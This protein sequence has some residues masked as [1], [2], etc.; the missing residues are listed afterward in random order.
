MNSS[1]FFSL[2]ILLFFAFLQPVYP[3]KKRFFDYNENLSNSL[4][5]Q[6]YEDNLG[7][8]WVATEDGLNRFDGIRFKPYSKGGN[9]RNS[10]KNNYV[11]SLFEDSKHN[12]WIG[13]INGLQ[14]FNYQNEEFCDVD[15]DFA[16]KK[17]G[18]HLFIKDITETSDGVIWLATTQGLLKIEKGK[19]I[20]LT[21]LN[22]QLNSIFINDILVDSDGLFWLGTRA[23]I[24]TYDPVSGKVKNYI[25]D[26]K[27]K[28]DFNREVSCLCEDNQ[29][30]I[31]V[32][33]ING[34]VS[35][36]LKGKGYIEKINSA[37]Q[38]EENLPVRDVLF[39]SKKRL[40][41]GTDGFGLRILNEN[42][43][44]LERYASANTSFNFFKSKVHTIIEDKAGNIWIGLFQKGIFLIPESPDIFINYGYKTIEENSIGSNCITDIDGNE[45]E[46]WISTDGDG[47]YHLNRKTDK[48]NHILIKN[49][50][51][52]MGGQN[53]LTMYNDASGDLWLGRYINGLIRYNK[54]SGTFK[55][56]KRT[57]TKYNKATYSNI[58]V[59]K[60]MNPDELVVGTLDDGIARFNTTTG[61][62]TCGLDLP[63]SLNNKIPKWILNLQI[64]AKGNF[65]IGTYVGLFYVDMKKPS[66]AQLT[67][68]NNALPDNTVSCLHIDR[69]QNIWAGTYGGIVKIRPGLMTTTFYSKKNGL[70]NNVISAIEEDEAGMIWISTH[71]GLS[72]FNP[73]TRLF[74]N[75]SSYD[76]I[77]ANEFTRNCSFCTEKN[78]LFFGGINGVTQIKR[79]YKECLEKIKDVFL[80]G[81]YLSGKSVNVSEKSGNHVILKKSIVFADTLRFMESDNQFSIGFVSAEI[82]NQSKIGYEYFMDGFDTSWRST[83]SRNRRGTYTNLRHGTY[84]F[85]VRAKDKGLYSKIRKLVIIIF[86]PWY[87]TSWAKL[88]LSVFVVFLCFCIFIFFRER[89]R[90]HHAEKMS[91]MKMQFFINVSHEIKTPLSLILDPLETL[92][93]RSTDDKDKKLL[94]IIQ[95]NANRIRRQVRQL[96]DVRKIDKGQLFVKFQEI[97]IFDFIKEIAE[98]YDVWVVQ[99][100]V[101]FVICPSDPEVTAWIDP[102]NFEKVIHNLL[103]NAFKFTAEG[104]EIKLLIE[105]EKGNN[106]DL[107]LPEYLKI[108]VSDN[109]LGIKEG[110]EE[111][112]F[113]R[114]YQVDAQE[115]RFPSGTGIGLNLS[116]SLVMLHKGKMYAENRTDCQG[117]IFVVLIPLGNK[118]IAAEDI[119]TE[120]AEVKNVCFNTKSVGVSNYAEKKGYR[121]PTAKT[122][123]KIMLIEDEPEVRNY[124]FEELSPLYTVFT[125]ENGKVA[126]EAVFDENPDLIISD[127]MMPEMDGI[128]LCKKIKNNVLI[129]H[130]PVVLLTALS[131]E[132]DRAEGIETGADMYLVKP[133]SS[134][135]LKKVIHNILENR[136][137]IQIQTKPVIG[138]KIGN[139]NVRP[140]NEVLMQ[141]V[142]DII[143]ENISNSALNV[144]MLAGEIGISRVHLHRK[145][146]ELT[147]QPAGDFIKSIRLKQAAYLLT[148]KEISISEAAYAVGFSNLSHFSKSFKAFY[149]VSPTEYAAKQHKQY[150][151]RE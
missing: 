6:I 79:D 96:M 43:G 104:G 101:D 76:G 62:F 37:Y 123:Y 141:K 34:G 72:R 114:F 118:H 143:K 105:K 36:I 113:N 60:R 22:K 61:N 70:C 17:K 39:D 64:D 103:S 117:S 59:I 102:L 145:L 73:K 40:W 57:P 109:G 8:L 83:N 45:N 89:Y 146:K 23:G 7:F 125:C 120:L 30:N 94:G 112:I 138:Q 132:E 28:N 108:V 53:V 122:D 147:N 54:K 15:V 68:E 144:E 121:K 91:E 58:T 142:M 135:F 16:E 32:G 11:T 84:K 128:S 130:I 69:E 33:Y 87:K 10:L 26:R 78:E 46:L 3:Q 107:P 24:I 55:A 85:Y 25:V 71:N 2:I 137:K 9:S 20:Y 21:N 56:F 98:A 92:I 148:T 80:T 52:N 75:Y 136:R 100:K 50:A 29:G 66:V 63:D 47:L 86:P 14:V 35:R 127:I 126:Y 111:R 149:G 27:G 65:W 74:T 4:I 131:K 110:D 48:V 93:K 95:Q 88:L 151:N 116:R 13:Q 12:L 41:V 81:F 134:D 31:I 44:Q 67:I 51:G 49:E 18:I 42:T 1:K 5:N 77:Q 19:T 139:I 90:F 133:F 106:N 129:N 119:L 115:K 82:A 150:E 140:H 38:G 99:K 97:R 124:L